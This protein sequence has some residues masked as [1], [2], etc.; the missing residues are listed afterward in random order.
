[1]SMNE[2]NINYIRQ[3]CQWMLDLE[4]LHSIISN[5]SI[6]TSHYQ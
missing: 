6:I 4:D 2:A 5:H 3:N 1:M